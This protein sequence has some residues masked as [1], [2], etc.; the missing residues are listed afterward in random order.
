M[1]ASG[2]AG[3]LS[4]DL[5]QPRP[6]TRVLGLR[7]HRPAADKGLMKVSFLALSKATEVAAAAALGPD[8]V[9]VH[10][11][12][13]DFRIC[14]WNGTL[15]GCSFASVTADRVESVSL[16]GEQPIELHAIQHAIS[17]LPLSDPV[18]EQRSQDVRAEWAEA[19][20]ELHEVE[21]RGSS[22]IPVNVSVAAVGTSGAQGEWVHT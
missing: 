2:G 19:V 3:A 10:D 15:D 1:Q 21:L 12:V 16:V 5:P 18:L 14:A 4:V 8:Y 7:A 17:V 11:P 13:T 22:P 20:L 6:L 9:A